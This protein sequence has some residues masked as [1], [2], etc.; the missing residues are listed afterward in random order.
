MT[1]EAAISYLRRFQD[2]RTGKDDRTMDSAG[3]TPAEIGKALET[4]IA[5]IPVLTRSLSSARSQLAKCQRQRE[6]FHSRLRRK[7]FDTP[8]QECPITRSPTP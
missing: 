8:C 2:W 4:V 6:E 1:T 7:Q 3:I 5:A